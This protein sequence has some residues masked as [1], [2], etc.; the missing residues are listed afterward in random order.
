MAVGAGE[1]Q[2]WY[3]LAEIILGVEFGVVGDLERL[4][5]HPF[6]KRSDAPPGK[7]KVPVTPKDRPPDPV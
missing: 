2:C 6:K 3:S 4:N 7:S 5:P 1:V